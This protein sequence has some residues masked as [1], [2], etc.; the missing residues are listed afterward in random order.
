MQTQQQDRLTIAK[1]LLLTIGAAIGM[2][3]FNPSLRSI[4]WSL[5]DSWSRVLSGVLCGLSLPAMCFVIGLRLQGG[6]LGPGAL[7]AFMSGLASLFFLP[8]ILI[9][10]GGIEAGSQFTQP[11]LNYVMPLVGVWFLAAAIIGRATR[12]Q[13]WLK[14][15]SWTETFGYVLAIGWSLQG[16]WILYIIHSTIRP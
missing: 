7:F 10:G 13:V 14:A 2:S 6:R 12:P 3:C 15:T 11:C 1:L 16:I 8:S 5:A 9:A 4:N